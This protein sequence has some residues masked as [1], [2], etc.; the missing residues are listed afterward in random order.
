MY[1]LVYMGMPVLRGGGGVLFVLRME[2]VRINIFYS[3]G[4][5]C[6]LK[7]FFSLVKLASSCIIVSVHV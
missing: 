7:V 6:N 4:M 1:I 5:R 3:N 2:A